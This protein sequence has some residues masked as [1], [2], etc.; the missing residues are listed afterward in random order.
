M[1]AGSAPLLLATDLA[2]YLV[3]RGAPFREAHELVG[4]AVAHATETGTP[5]DRLD[6]ATVSPEFGPDARE[7]FD[8]EHAL[9]ARTSPGAP[10]IENIRAEIERWKPELESSSF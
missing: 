8:P 3:R 4:R 2:D 10:S 7:V 1:E 5:L 6:L 9:A